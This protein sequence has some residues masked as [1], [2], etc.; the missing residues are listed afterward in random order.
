[1]NKLSQRHGKGVDEVYTVSN[2]NSNSRY[3]LHNS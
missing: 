3:E 1:M 2:S